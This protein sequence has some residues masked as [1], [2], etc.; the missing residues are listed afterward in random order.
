MRSG[1]LVMLVLMGGCIF[2]VPA[3]KCFA[4]GPTVTLTGKLTS[5]VF[6]GPPNYESIRKGDAKETAILLVL[7][8]PICTST[9]DPVTYGDPEKGQGQIQ[10]VITKD[11]DWPIIRRL[12]GKR[13]AV[14]GALF[15]WSTG[16]HHTSVLIDVSQVRAVT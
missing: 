16:H 10:L 9:N 12:M 14:S 13:A 2:S 6:P 7:S 5:K 8:H 1:F 3:Q 4:C 11:G 15:H